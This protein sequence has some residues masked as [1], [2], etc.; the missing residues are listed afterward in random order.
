MLLWKHP[1]NAKQAQCGKLWQHLIFEKW[2]IESCKGHE[3]LW[4]SPCFLQFFLLYIHLWGG[5]WPNG[6]F[7]KMWIQIAIFKNANKL[8]KSTW[9]RVRTLLELL[10]FLHTNQIFFISYA[11]FV[12]R[13]FWLFYVAVSDKYM[14]SK[15]CHK[16]IRERLL[17]LSTVFSTS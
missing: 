12:I 8:H 5:I 7:S 6:S 11:F 16:G 13:R 1:N 14:L 10:N 3:T 15:K 4:V 9:K 2:E 17:V